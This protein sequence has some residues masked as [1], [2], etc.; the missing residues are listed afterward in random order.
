MRVS[1]IRRLAISGGLVAAAFA[2]KY[3]MI[4][5]PNVE[6]L[7][8]AFFGV[9]YAYGAIW[10]AFVGAVGEAIFATVNPMGAPIAPVWVAQIMGMAL[11]GVIGG[12]MGRVGK[13]RGSAGDSPGRS[14]SGLAGSDSQWG[15]HSCPP[16]GDAERHLLENSRIGESGRWR[17]V[18]I[19]CAGIVAT[20]SFDLLTNLAMA[21][22]IGPFWAIMIAA[23]PFA[24]VHLLS[25][26][27]LFALIFPILR[28]WLT[29]YTSPPRRVACPSHHG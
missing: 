29:R 20:I 7:T 13:H 15:G 5:L 9:G 27:L 2:V 19:V 4:G 12:V 24:A 23:I 6:P 14:R 3:A 8:L 25:N 17:L 10:G 26:A 18:M 16:V 1:E 28:R 21:W 11:V 22:S